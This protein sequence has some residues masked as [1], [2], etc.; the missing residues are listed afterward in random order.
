MADK[1]DE[2]IKDHMMESGPGDMNKIVHLQEEASSKPV[3]SNIIKNISR[4]FKQWEKSNFWMQNLFGHCI[5]L[6][7]DIHKKQGN[8]AQ[9][10]SNSNT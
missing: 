10:A 4:I 3:Q 5:H 1:D 8:W 2:S 6:M 9:S 7:K